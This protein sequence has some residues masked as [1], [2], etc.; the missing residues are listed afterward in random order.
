MDIGAEVVVAEVLARLERAKERR[1]PAKIIAACRSIESVFAELTRGN[2]ETPVRS[3]EKCREK[4]ARAV[5]ALLPEEKV[6][7]DKSTAIR[8]AQ[9]AYARIDRNRGL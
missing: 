3:L 8:T 2:S 1:D 6:E 7:N 9:S 5:A 4:V